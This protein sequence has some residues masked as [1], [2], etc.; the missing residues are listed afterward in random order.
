MILP[1]GLAEGAVD[2]PQY[3]QN[4]TIVATGGELELKTTQLFLVLVFIV[5]TL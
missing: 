2:L 4:F 5:F 1:G 3:F